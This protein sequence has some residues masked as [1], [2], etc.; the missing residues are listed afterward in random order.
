[1]VWLLLAC[2]AERGPRDASDTVEYDGYVYQGPNASAETLLAS[3]EL[4]FELDD[5]EPVEAAQPYAEDYPGYWRA[6]LPASAPFTLRIA[7]DG[8]YPAVWRGVAPAADG[9]WFSGALFGGSTAEVDAWFA[10]FALPDAVRLQSLA[11]GEVV[12]VWGAPW[13]ADAWDCAA[14]RVAD[15]PV[16]CF[17]QDAAT[18]L[19]IPV[20]SG[21]FT[22]FLAVNLQPGELVVD[23][24]LGGRE[25]YVARGGE[26]V[27]AFWFLGEG[28]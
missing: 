8:A 13:D 11:D 1:M 25:T 17:A 3:G 5:G 23:S 7:A 6:E 2:A 12:H 26:L 18:G 9:A 16:Y 19:V 28:T 20:E 4:R 21:P 14:V 15:E 22:W 24:G 27:Y 10:A